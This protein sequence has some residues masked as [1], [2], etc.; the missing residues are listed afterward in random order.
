MARTYLSRTKDD[1]ETLMEKGTPVNARVISV[2]K[3]MFGK[4]YTVKVVP[5]GGPYSHRVFSQDF[6]E[7]RSSTDVNTTLTVY[8]DEIDADG[9]FYID[10]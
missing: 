2:K 3:K 9:E 7:I 10:A 6:E 8:I 5:I 1:K 4:G